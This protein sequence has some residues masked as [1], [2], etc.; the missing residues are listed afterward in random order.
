MPS[1]LALRYRRLIGDER[2]EVLWMAMCWT[3]VEP[4]TKPVDVDEVVRRLGGGGDEGREQPVDLDNVYDGSDGAFY[5][6]QVGSAV[7]VLEVNGFQ[8]SRPQGPP[9]AQ[10]WRPGAQCVLVRQ[11]QPVQ[12]C[13]VRQDA[14]FV[15]GHESVRSLWGGP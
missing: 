6:G 13:G 10:R 12:L 14:R 15:C 11:R 4:V 9:R 5:V 8:G 3:V 7:A 2:L 1:D